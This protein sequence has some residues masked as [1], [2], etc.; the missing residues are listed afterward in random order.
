[1]R[2]LLICGRV[3]AVALAGLA[4]VLAV[5]VPVSA[6]Y[7]GFGDTGFTHTNKGRCCEDAVLMARD[8]S[9]AQCEQSGGFPNFSRSSARGR[10]DWETQR[11]SNGRTRFRCTATATVT[12]R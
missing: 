5:T 11:D 8:D 7:N 9:A 10:C 1:M 4:L 2:R 3:A 6:N 12:C